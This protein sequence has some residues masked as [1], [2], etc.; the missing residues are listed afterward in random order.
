LIQ[1]RC[2]AIQDEKAW[3]AALLGLPHSIFHTWGYAHAIWLTTG[4]VTYLYTFEDEAVRII[5]P[6]AEREIESHRDLVTPFGIG[7][8]AGN[9]ESQAFA[10]HW[11]AFAKRMGYVC[12]YIGLNPL[13]D[14]PCFSRPG[15]AVTE[16]TIFVMDLSVDET[17][18]RRRLA[19]R[20]RR[21]IA[22]LKS[23]RADLVEDRRS[24]TEF[25]VSNYLPFM[26]RKGAAPVYRFRTATLEALC[27]LDSVLLVGAARRGRIEAVMMFGFTPY[28]ADGLFV[29]SH[30]GCEHHSTPLI[31]WAVKAMQARDVPLLNLGGAVREGD[32]LAAYKRRFG[33][34][35]L[36]MRA[37]KQ[38]YRPDTYA[39]LCR[40]ASVGQDDQGYFPAYRAR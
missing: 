38:I 36:P 33:S 19:P 22:S 35:S 34:L 23:P 40:R 7:G 11:W 9:G 16:R 18:V 4:L 10:D 31:W 15:E 12:G 14:R 30:P 6:L 1:D 39:D 3:T 32:G 5:C 13:F 37:L 29:P 8:F 26:E 28:S 17:E 25:F 24:L 20:L 2:I 21:E 27:S